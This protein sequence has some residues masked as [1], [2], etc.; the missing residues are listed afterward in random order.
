[1]ATSVILRI[2]SD[3][4]L[5]RASQRILN[6]PARI[7]NM[8][9]PPLAVPPLSDY[10]KFL[11]AIIPAAPPAPSACATGKVALPNQPGVQFASS[12]RRIETQLFRQQP[13]VA[14]VVRDKLAAPPQATKRLQK[15]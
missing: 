9:V 15:A 5:H 8:P 6:A 2:H 4:I 12:L 3:G 7:N 14:L 13:Y 1:M 11:E 10:A